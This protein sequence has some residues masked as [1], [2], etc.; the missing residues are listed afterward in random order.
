VTVNNVSFWWRDSANEK[1]VVSLRL[2]E[3]LRC[4]LLHLLARGFV[5]IRNF[6]FFAN[7]Q[8]AALLQYCLR[9]LGSAPASPPRQ[10]LSTPSK[11]ASFKVAVSEPPAQKHCH[12]QR[13]NWAVQI[14]D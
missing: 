7:R 3:F 13:P 11:A 10:P 6:G 2:D 5:R 8:R 14:Q 1:R 9:L 4:F 12:D